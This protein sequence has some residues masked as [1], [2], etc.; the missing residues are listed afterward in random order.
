[1][2]ASLPRPRRRRRLGAVG[3]P[4]RGL[5]RQGVRHHLPRAGAR[6]KRGAGARGRRIFEKCDDRARRALRARRRVSRPSRRRD[7]W[8]RAKPDRWRAFAAAVV[9][10]VAVVGADLRRSEFIQ[11]PDHARVH[12]G[13]FDGDRP[14]RPPARLPRG[15]PRAGLG[16][17]L[18]RSEPDDPIHGRQLCA[19][20]PPRFRGR[21]LPRH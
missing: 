14:G 6:S 2:G 13:D 7:V 8:R 1:M 11:R 19:T 4:R 9:A 18:S 12:C 16:L 10:A 21:R 15:A 20:D 3:G 17:R 5:L